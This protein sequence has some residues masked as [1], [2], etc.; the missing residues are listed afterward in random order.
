MIWLGVWEYGLCCFVLLVLVIVVILVVVVLGVMCFGGGID[1]IGFLMLICFLNC[2]F[3]CF[4]V[5][6]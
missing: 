1:W 5:V 4:F 3:C 2:V 6:C